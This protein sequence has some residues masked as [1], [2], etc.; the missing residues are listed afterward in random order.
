MDLNWFIPALVKSKVGSERGTTGEDGTIMRGHGEAL[1]AITSEGGAHS[2]KVSRGRP[3]TKSMTILLEKV[4]KRFSHTHSGPARSIGHHPDTGKGQSCRTKANKARRGEK[5]NPL[6]EM[7]Q[8]Q[9]SPP[10]H[11]RNPHSRQK[12][13][14]RPHHRF[15][16]GEGF[17]FFSFSLL[18]LFSFFF[19]LP[20]LQ[21][22]SSS[23]PQPDENGFGIDTLYLESLLIGWGRTPNNINN[24][25][26]HLPTKKKREKKKRDPRANKK[27]RNTESDR[28]SCSDLGPR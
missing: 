19:S 6:A 8:R 10:L 17:L 14:I 27:E 5:W 11:S 23:F 18:L 21:L 20:P 1:L 25:P 16:S 24:N 26:L 3:P 9:Y 22:V 4:E 12:K 28:I 13:K 15:L 7:S 2:R